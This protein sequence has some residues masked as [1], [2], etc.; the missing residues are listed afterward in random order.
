MILWV[1]HTA[2]YWYVTNTTVFDFLK[3]K[4]K[5]KTYRKSGNNSPVHTTSEIIACLAWEPGERNG[6]ILST[7]FVVYICLAVGLYNQQ[8]CPVYICFDHVVSSTDFCKRKTVVSLAPQPRMH[9]RGFSAQ[10]WGFW[11]DGKLRLTKCERLEEWELF[12]ESNYQALKFDLW[13]AFSLE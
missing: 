2:N 13:I 7:V 3:F 4:L 8:K 1:Y 10:V 9:E 12:N 5:K 6:N 11:W